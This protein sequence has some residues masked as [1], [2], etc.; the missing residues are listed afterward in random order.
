MIGCFIPNSSVM[1][2]FNV[3]FSLWEAF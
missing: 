1:R 2:V 3:G